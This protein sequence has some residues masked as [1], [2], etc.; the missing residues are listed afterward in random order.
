MHMWMQAAFATQTKEVVIPA[1][2][3][4]TLTAAK[5]ASCIEDGNDAYYTCSACG[6]Y[7]A[8]AAGE[9]ELVEG[10]WKIPA[11]HKLTLTPANEASCTESGNDAYYTCS[12]CG[13]YFADAAG[14]EELVEGAWKIPAGHKLTLTPAKEANC[15]EEGNTAYYTCSV[16]NHYFSDA[17][18][19]N[20][21]NEGSWKEGVNP[22]NHNWDVSKIEYVWDREYA[23][24]DAS[25]V[26]TRDPSHTVSEHAETEFTYD[27]GDENTSGWQK[28]TAVF[29]KE[30]FTTQVKKIDYDEPVMEPTD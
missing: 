7:F 18:G 26:C 29:T 15:T 30:P 2:H 23:Y 22:D 27:E 6:H 11:G 19:E 8:D 24:V 4:L 5:E 13:H 10:V 3:T 28:Y 14:E 12:V 16:C 9:E 17:N 1:G 25:C 21:I 20:E